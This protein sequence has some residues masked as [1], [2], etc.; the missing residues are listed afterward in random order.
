LNLPR[1]VSHPADHF[2]NPRDDFS[3]S[4]DFFRSLSDTQSGFRKSLRRS[5][6]SCLNLCDSQSGFE[7]VHN[8]R[9][10]LPHWIARDQVKFS[11]IPVI[12][13][14]L[15]FA[16]SSVRQRCAVKVWKSPRDPNNDQA[17]EEIKQDNS[18]R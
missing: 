1:H 7:R 3:A 10:H 2:R 13:S 14:E 17:T 15:R 6:K 11:S 18:V 4:S 8:G 9:L 16:F 12:S 5:M